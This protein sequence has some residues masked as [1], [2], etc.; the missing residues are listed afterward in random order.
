MGEKKQ[1]EQVFEAPLRARRWLNLGYA[2]AILICS[3]G[4]GALGWVILA[5]SRDRV[6]I[7]SVLGIMAVAFILSI[8]LVLLILYVRALMRFRV[9][10]MESIIEVGSGRTYRTIRCDDVR[11]IEQQASQLCV[12][13]AHLH[14]SVRFPGREG[15]EVANACVSALR[16][17]CRNAAYINVVGEEQLPAAPS[18]PA[19]PLKA[20]ENHYLLKIWPGIAVAAF[21][22]TV[23]LGGTASCLRAILQHNDSPHGSTMNWICILMYLYVLQGAFPAIKRTLPHVRR[24][25]EVRKSLSQLRATVSK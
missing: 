13:G 12:H 22:G 4:A 7:R 1:A 17:S 5:I 18:D 14:L 24:L 23:G 20:L 9:R 10:I 16:E 25:R 19:S 3:V 2:A 11:L 6:E 15:W 21:C 8:F